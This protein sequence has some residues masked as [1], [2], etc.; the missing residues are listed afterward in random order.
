MSIVSIKL[1]SKDLMTPKTAVLGKS[2][3]FVSLTYKMNFTVK[4]FAVVVA[5]S[6]KRRTVTLPLRLVTKGRASRQGQKR[7]V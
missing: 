2:W 1:S 4:Q 3:R 6:P 5:V 7:C